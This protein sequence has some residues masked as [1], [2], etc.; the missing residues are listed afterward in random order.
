V[1]FDEWFSEASLTEKIDEALATLDQRG[2]SMKK[3]AIFGLNQLN[4]AMRKTVWSNVVMVKP[5][6]LHLTLLTI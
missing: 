4:L 1:T 2:F 6:I 3:M 5:L